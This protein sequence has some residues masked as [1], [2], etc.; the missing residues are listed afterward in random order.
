MMEKQ[1]A[2][3]QKDITEDVLKRVTELTETGDLHLPSDYSPANALKSAMI[4]LS[5]AKTKDGKPVLEHCS[6]PSISLSLLKMCV[7]GLSP[8]KG[9]CYF[10]PYGN[11]LQYSRSYQG[12]MSLAKR[13][14]G[15]KSINANV[16]YEGDDFSFSID[17]KT[18]LKKID[19]HKP[20]INNIDNNRILGAYAVIIYNDGSVDA[21]VM[22]IAEIRQA[23]NQGA[24]KGNSPAHKNFTQ[25]MAKKTVINRACKTPIN[26]SSDAP[27]LLGHKDE[28][29]EEEIVDVSHEVVEDVSTGTAQIDFQETETSEAGF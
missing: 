23:W 21:E 26:S 22:T 19:S 12:S 6:K 7:E 3:K 28:F 1:P 18:G 16:I 9:Q 20:S 25:E 10:I 8:M 24:T 29:N 17:S 14:G 4:L 5:E 27:L 2:I 15:V 11:E 13:F